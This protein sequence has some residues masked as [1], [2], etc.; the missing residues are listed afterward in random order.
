MNTQIPHSNK[1]KF[2]EAGQI[3]LFLGIIVIVVVS[4]LAFII[5]VGLFVKAKINLQ[6]AVDS[7]AFSGAAVQARQLTNVSY[8][9]WE[10]RNTFK[11]WMFKYYVLGQKGLDQTERT[12]IAGHSLN[13]GNMNFRLHSFY[14]PSDGSAYDPDAYDRFNVPTICIHYGSPHNICQI[15]SVPGLPR[16]NT[17]GLPSISEHHESFLNTLVQ[18]KAKDCSSRSQ[19][20]MGAAMLW[21]YGT[22]F[23]DIPPNAPQ[24][25]A[26]RPGAWIQALELGIRIRN[27]EAIINTPP[28]ED[29]VCRNPIAGTSCTSIQEIETRI[30]DLPHYERTVKAFNAAF[31]NLGGGANKEAGGQTDPLFATFRLKE[32]KPNPYTAEALS[33]SGFLIPSGSPA[34]QKHYLDLQI[35]PINYVTFF[36][37][38]TSQT[39]NFKGTSTRSEANCGAIKAALP[40]PG[41]ISGFTKNP[42]VLTYY[43]VKGEAEFVGLFFPFSK[44]S[45]I[46]LKAYA[47]A[48]PMGGRIGP[49]LFKIE[50]NSVFPR[51]EAE[52]QLT[53]N[54]SSALDVSTLSGAANVRGGFPIPTVPNFW[55]NTSTNIAIGGNPISGSQIFFTLPN[56][57]YDF[58]DVGELDKTEFRNQRIQTLTK[59]I[60]DTEA[61][62]A[63]I[64]EGSGLYDQNQ[65]KL[66]E[67]NQDIA[68]GPTLNAREVLQSIFNTR[69]P[70]RYEA[71]NYMI[72]V[73]AE[74]G[75]NPAE[76]D[77]SFYFYH[78]DIDP[79]PLTGT[80]YYSIFGPMYGPNVLY[81]QVASITNTVIDYINANTPAIDKYLKALRDVADAIRVDSASQARDSAA[82][83]AAANTIHQD[84]EIISSSAPGSSTCTS[85]SLAQTFATF[86]KGTT[87]GCGITP[88]GLRVTEYFNELSQTNQV[89]QNYFTTTYEIRDLAPN[90]TRGL[91]NNPRYLMTGF[92]PG[93]RQGATQEGGIQ[94]PFGNDLPVL[95]KRSF[96]S[97][98]L[99]AMQKVVAN[100]ASKARTQD[101]RGFDI[102]AVFME[103]SSSGQKFVS[104][105]DFAGIQVHNLI[106]RTE[107]DEWRFLDL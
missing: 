84:P 87:E 74:D 71:L 1:K 107:I 52:K 32:L 101:Q 85:P 27:L 35:Y 15:A 50:G 68:S 60:N 81:D 59:A 40:V 49:K 65:F 99:F 34:L 97:T 9:N 20:N 18:S 76:I 28:V 23:S 16:F 44:T 57:L 17:V 62:S 48:K 12:Q 55:A 82:Y 106:D 64:K 73:I 5:N 56:L 22:G 91:D 63:S 45:G 88:L 2:K 72:P 96:Y 43:A 80:R 103:G 37:L 24:I 53:I 77:H 92:S 83:E 58:E 33:L 6:N 36:T 89:Y 61:Y 13:N 3:S 98:K 78:A 29:P 93:P 86:F 7:A 100:S 19:V 51:D 38:F 90:L 66:F 47:A 8:L 104:S 21:A 41:Y 11:E 39:A 95:S 4:F 69:R 75:Q 79:H 30:S 10:L 31:R 14:K 54:Y 102:P 94:K 105:T 67:A 46:N 42:E 25:A 26:E 70:T